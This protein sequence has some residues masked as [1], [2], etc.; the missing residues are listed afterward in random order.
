MLNVHPLNLKMAMLA[1]DAILSKDFKDEVMERRDKLKARA[2]EI[3]KE[4][5]TQDFATCMSIAVALTH[6][7]MQTLA[8]LSEALMVK[9]LAIA[10]ENLSEKSWNA[11]LEEFKKLKLE[12][13]RW[14]ARQNKEWE[15][16]GE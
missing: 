13:I 3:R 11:S 12:D 5:P 2:L 16:E 4:D 7:E 6:S 9:F 15:K 10:F 14:T 1:R 8:T